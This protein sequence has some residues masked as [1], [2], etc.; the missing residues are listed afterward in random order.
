[1]LPYTLR[2]HLARSIQ[3]KG[4]DYLSN[5]Q[6]RRAFVDS[7]AGS[8]EN[9]TTLLKMVNNVTRDNLLVQLND[10]ALVMRVYE[11]YSPG[12]SKQELSSGRNYM[13]RHILYPKTRQQKC[14]RRSMLYVYLMKS[15]LMVKIHYLFII[16]FQKKVLLSATNYMGLMGRSSII[17]SSGNCTQSKVCRSMRLS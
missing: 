6:K 2:E 17:A 11:H 4:V 10:M 15:G 14:W 5:L 16:F 3:V 8:K 13:L 9:T 1:M 7:V 12:A